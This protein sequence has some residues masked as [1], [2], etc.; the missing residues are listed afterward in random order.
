MIIALL[1]AAVAT[2]FYRQQRRWGIE[3]NLAQ[4][5]KT[6]QDPKEP[7]HQEAVAHLHKMQFFHDEARDRGHTYA[8]LCVRLG[9]VALAVYALWFVLRTVVFAYIASAVRG[10]D[11]CREVCVPEV[12]ANY[13]DSLAFWQSAA[14][15]VEW[16]FWLALV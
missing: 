13:V 8:G 7:R 15:H 5:N 16:L 1:L 6:A 2:W 3:A 11:A 12:T 4:R 14:D 9:L 10:L